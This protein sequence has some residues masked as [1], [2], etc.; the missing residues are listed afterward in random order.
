MAERGELPGS[1]R[2]KASRA[3]VAHSRFQGRQAKFFKVVV[4]TAL[5]RCVKEEIRFIP[6]YFDIPFAMTSSGVRVEASPLR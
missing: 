3:Q 1:T 5:A 4:R 2:K 6:W